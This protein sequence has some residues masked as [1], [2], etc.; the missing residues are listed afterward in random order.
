MADSEDEATKNF[1]DRVRIRGNPASLAEACSDA[2]VLRSSSLTAVRE[3]VPQD[4][5][6]HLRSHAEGAL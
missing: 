3:A 1:K 2:V 5:T 6:R 4:Q